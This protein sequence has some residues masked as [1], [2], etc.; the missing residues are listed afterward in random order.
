MRINRYRIVR[1][2]LSSSG[3]RRCAALA[4]LLLAVSAGAAAAQTVAATL[5]APPGVLLS[6]RAAGFDDTGT[7]PRFTSASFSTTDYY[8]TAEVRNGIVWVE[9]KTSEELNAL[10]SPPADPFTVR[11]EL[12]MT[13]DE[14]ETATRTVDLETDYNVVSNPTPPATPSPQPQT[15]AITAPPGVLVSLT[16]AD[17]FDDAGTNPRFTSATF[18][19][20]EYYSTAGIRDGVLWLQARTAQELN[21]LDSPPASPFTV[22]VDASMTNDEGDTATTTFTFETTYDRDSAGQQESD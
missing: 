7:N 1:P 10:A 22:T 9:A 2:Q 18:S 6:I 4:A 15:T 21:A 19:T 16:A 17:N 14:D 13:N 11:A 5:S 8:N 3:A 12:T 20:T